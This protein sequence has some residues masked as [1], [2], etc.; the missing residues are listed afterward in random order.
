MK[1]ARSTLSVVLSILMAVMFVVIIAPVSPAAQKWT[2]IGSGGFGDVKNFTGSAATIYNGRLVVGTSNIDG[3]VV[4]QYSG[5]KWNAISAPGFVIDGNDW[6]ESMIVFNGRLYAGTANDTQSGYGSVYRYTGTGKNWEWCP[7]FQGNTRATTSLAQGGGWLFAAQ[8]NANVGYVQASQD[9]VNWRLIYNG[10]GESVFK[11]LNSVCVSGDYIYAGGDFAAAG[12]NQQCGVIRGRIDEVVK[13]NLQA[14]SGIPK[15]WQDCGFPGESFTPGSN[16]AESVLEMTAGPN[17]SLVAG[18]SRQNGGRVLSMSYPGYWNALYDGKK[19]YRNI[20]TLFWDGGGN[21]LFT[22]GMDTAGQQGPSQ[23]HRMS[24]NGGLPEKISNDGFGDENNVAVSSVAALFG[25]PGSGKIGGGNNNFFMA[26]TNWDNGLEVWATRLE[27]PEPQWYFAEG[28]TG[29]GFSEWITVLNPDASKDA[30]VVVNYMFNNEPNPDA[31]VVNVPAASRFTINVNDDIGPN[32]EVSA[33]V[34]CTSGVDIF[35]ERPMYFQYSPG[36][37]G[38]HCVTGARAPSTTWYFAEGTTIDG[39]S[40]YITLQNP[41][42]DTATVKLDY[43]GHD[44]FINSYNVDVPGNSRN[45]V[46]VNQTASVVGDVSVKVESTNGMPIVAER[47]CYFEWSRNGG[48][49]VVGAPAPI[50]NCYFGE[51]YTGAGF[52]E[53]LLVQN[54]NDVE[55][56]ITVDFLVKGEGAI[57]KTGT[58]KPNSRRTIGVEGEVGANKEVGIAVSSDQG[59]IAE[60]AIYFDYTLEP[61]GQVP[62]AINGGHDVIGADFAREFYFAEGYTG[63]WYDEYLTLANPNEDEIEVQIEFMLEGLPNPASVTVAIPA[64]NRST[65]RVKDHVAENISV[66]CRLTCDQDFIAERPEYFWYQ[67]SIGGGHCVIGMEPPQ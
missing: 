57:R 40:E 5:G 30:T 36:C 1:A 33:Q 15:G 14:D 2:R 47:P 21:Y 49:C 59:I 24:V 7:F 31:T 66:S 44:G 9:G 53:W 11:H 16:L 6:I 45:T 63:T 50:M 55:A 8:Q 61:P 28:Y 52:V 62:V 20:S 25:H 51:G 56:N 67:D 46:N 60:R 41:N 10:L 64:G 12:G 3:A 13:N 29:P 27:A 17:E 18:T 23:V 65:V 35:V 26:T 39:F 42:D 54:P 38:G 22:T 37:Q 32:H 48:H 43:T 58:V 34:M 4:Y 19:D